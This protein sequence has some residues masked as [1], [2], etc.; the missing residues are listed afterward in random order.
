MS[1]KQGVATCQDKITDY[2]T[3]IFFGGYWAPESTFKCRLI[4]IREKKCFLNLPTEYHTAS[5]QCYVLI[6]TNLLL[7]SI[8]SCSAGSGVARVSAARGGS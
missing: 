7:M 8:S 4:I 1:Q 3:K 5:I 6:F 2:L